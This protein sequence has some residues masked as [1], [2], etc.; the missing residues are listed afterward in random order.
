MSLDVVILAAGKGTRMKSALPKVLQPLAGKPMLRHVTDFVARLGASQAQGAARAR[1][2]AQ[3]GTQ[4]GAQEA[5]AHVIIG[6]G[7]EAVREYYAQAAEAEPGLAVPNWV[8]QKEQ[9]GT[10]HA[11]QQAV[12]YLSGSD[13]GGKA[14]TP[15][16]TLVLYGDVPL[17]SQQILMDM[18]AL[19]ESGKVA[20]LTMVTEKPQGLGRILRDDSGTIT[21]I[22]EDKDADAKQQAIKEI[23]V[24]PMAIPTALLPGWLA[25]LDNKN[26]QKEYIL[27]HVVAL[28]VADG[29]PVDAT[30]VADSPE[31]LGV[32]DK[33]QL[34][35]VEQLYQERAAAAL[36]R[37]GVTLRHPARLDIRGSIDCGQDVEIDADVLLQGAVGLGNR[38]HIGPGAAL[39]NCTVGDDVHIGKGAMLTGCTLGDG[40]S[41]GAY[42]I[43]QDSQ[44]AS[45][46]Q[47]RAATQVEQADIGGGAT[48]GPQARIRPG[49]VLA[50]S[51]HI[52][53]FVET[54]NARIGKGS[55]ANHLA[56]IGDAVIG[57]ECNIGAGTIFC[58][59]D[60]ARK[61]QTVLGNRVFIG[62]NSTLVAPLELADDSF[63]AAGSTVT[64]AVPEGQ[65]AVGRGRQRNIS[66]WKRPR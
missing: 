34:A 18:V 6:A 48:V 10:G 57:A 37:E 26:R 38:V 58:N 51:V 28:A 4:K 19:A 5:R 63:V 39:K 25:R 41:I 32:N 12:P 52:G 54:K 42:A 1:G 9:L 16:V 65:L 40:V 17:M 46:A 61:H 62:S 3:Q 13:G 15:G 7:A 50:E 22:V 23:N 14:K 56:Y 8:V 59:Y 64:K 43:L 66:E 53:N 33:A 45:N 31:L 35:A 11:V 27:T 55:K 20:L 24:G 60:G 29:C 21:G 30:V 36:M 44:V 2:K 49:S 47:I